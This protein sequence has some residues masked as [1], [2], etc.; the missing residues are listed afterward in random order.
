MNLTQLSVPFL[1]PSAN[2]AYMTV[3]KKIK[4]KTASIRVLTK[5]GERF[6]TETKTYLTRHHAQELKYFQPNKPYCLLINF[7]FSR[8][9][10]LYVGSYPEKSENRY[11]KLDVGNRL[12]LF[13]D[14]LAQATGIDDSHNWML[15]L[16]KTTGKADATHV[17][18]WNMEDDPGP[19]TNL[20][21]SILSIGGVQQD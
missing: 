17:F 18:A 11:K 2:H 4:G 12:K 15:V 19:F 16:L 10:D 7:V 1:P 20:A 3:L 14:A 21:A 6:K 13:E 9:S 5:E 8:K